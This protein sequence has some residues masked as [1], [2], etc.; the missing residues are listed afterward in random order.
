MS[1]PNKYPAILPA[2]PGVPADEVVA[3]ILSDSERRQDEMKLSPKERQALL[4]ARRKE[5][6]RKEKA[7]QKAQGQK[8]HRLFL[9]LP[10]DLKERLSNLASW[11]GT[12]VSQIATYLLYEALALYDAG[13]IDFNRHKAPSYSPRYTTELIHPNDGEHQQR[14]SA[15]KRKRGRGW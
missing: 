7:R 4:A 9:L 2:L 5:S 14:Y 13:Q 1:D 8:E 3:D 11:N 12:S 6:E 15:Q 10:T